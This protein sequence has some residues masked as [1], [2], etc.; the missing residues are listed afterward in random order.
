M[1]KKQILASQVQVPR[2]KSERESNPRQPPPQKKLILKAVAEAD[3]SIAK[4]RAE[5]RQKDAELE[6]IHNSRMKATMTAQKYQQ[7]DIKKPKSRASKS[8][9]STVKR[10]KKR[11]K[12]SIPEENALDS[13]DEFKDDLRLRLEKR[14]KMKSIKKQQQ[15]LL[16]EAEAE[17]ITAPSPPKK[18]TKRLKKSVKQNVVI[19][20]AEE[21]LAPPVKIEPLVES[22]PKEEPSKNDDQDAELELIRQRALNSMMKNR[23]RRESGE[24]TKKI[25]IP[26]NED[27]SSDDSSTDSDENDHNDEN[28]SLSSMENTSRKDEPMQDPKFIVTL[29]GINSS[30]FKHG[31]SKHN[32]ALTE[33]SLKTTNN[34][35]VQYNNKPAAIIAPMKHVSHDSTKAEPT[36]QNKPKPEVTSPPPMNKSRK[37]ITAPEKSPVKKLKKTETEKPLD[38]LKKEV[39]KKVEEA[40]KIKRIRPKITAPE[41]DPS[42]IPVVTTK[43]VCK[44]WPRCKRGDSCIYLHPKSPRPVLNINTPLPPVSSKDK[45]KWTSSNK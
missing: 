16:D 5:C 9:S 25:I 27:T 1:L 19:K 8:E 24:A 37:R 20:E 38:F 42:P 44:F 28:L 43:E 11:V 45:F 22:E 17:T 12:S 41:P 6:E 40:A 23:Q 18:S 35:A 30:Y 32:E 36:I 29:D 15:I 13:P 26:L 2:K 3:K 21:V 14:R 4:K 31:S 34:N 10:K 33:K 7:K 39:V